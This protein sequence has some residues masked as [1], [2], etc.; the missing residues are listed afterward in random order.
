MGSCVTFEDLCQMM[1]RS[2]P[3]LDDAPAVGEDLG[4]TTVEVVEE[5]GVKYPLT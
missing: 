1:S 3:D 2:S 4:E 5:T